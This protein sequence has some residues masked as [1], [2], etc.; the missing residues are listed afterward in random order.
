MKTRL[1]AALAG[2]GLALAAGLVAVA[3]PAANATE[4]GLSFATCANLEGWYVNGDETDRRPTATE[5]G[6]KFEG[7]DL[8]HHQITGVTVDNL[9]PGTFEASPDPDQPSFFS[10]EVWDSDRSGY[11]TL[12]WNTE[13]DEW[14]MVREGQL[15]AHDNPAE[16]V[17][18]TDP[19]RSHTVRS[20]GVGYTKNPPGT[21]ATVVSSVT[22]NG[23]VYDL[24]CPATDPEP[25]QTATPGPGGTATP[26]PTQTAT[27]G[28]VGTATPE[29][30]Q[31]AAPLPT[32]PVTGSTPLWFALAG[33]AALGSGAL[34]FVLAR[35]RREVTFR[36]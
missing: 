7:D 2:L 25:T 29:P 22:F 3:A 10:V 6:L 19:D 4:S 32:L 11:A 17:K 5:A 16:L 18:L 33:L 13:T 30:T 1:A 28:P 23:Q 31:S 14:N 15:Y 12:R 9:T 21:V 8:I 34:L 27:P 36:S 20:F 26:E 35:R 24:T